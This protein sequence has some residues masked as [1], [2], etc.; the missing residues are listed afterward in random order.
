MFNKLLNSTLTDR[1]L[2]TRPYAS[3]CHTNKWVAV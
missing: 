3:Y 1:A 2:D